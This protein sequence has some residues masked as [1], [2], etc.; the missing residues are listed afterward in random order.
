M[1]LVPAGRFDMGSTREAERPVHSVELPAFCMDITEVTVGA[2]AECARA[3]SCV[4]AWTTVRWANIG[5]DRDDPRPQCNGDRADR[6]EHPVNCVDLAQASSFCAFARKRLP[7]EEEWE[8]AARGDES[9]VYAWGA[10]APGTQLCWAGEGND[11]GIG[12][13]LA[14]CRAGAYPLGASTEGIQD[15]AGNV[16]EWTSSKHSKDYA[17][18]PDD[19]AYVMRG[20][21]WGTRDAADVRGA[22]RKW[23]PR[24]YRNYYLGFR[25][26]ADAR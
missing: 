18:P 21:G 5:D 3:K 8:H 26:V 22:T 13:R 11:V 23:L 15:L 24:S 19:T 10:S 1:A 6:R 17:S 20:G 12:R 16:W 2:Y 4:P 7:T 25:C 9:R 14:T